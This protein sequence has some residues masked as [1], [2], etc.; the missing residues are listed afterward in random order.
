MTYRDLANMI[1]AHIRKEIIDRQIVSLAMDRNEF[2]KYLFEVWYLY[3]DPHA[4]RD[5]E[6]GICRA[7]VKDDFIKIL[8]DLITL[9]KEKNLLNAI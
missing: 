3:I 9:E 2:S 5:W 4:A 7:K 1:P 8:P 6:C